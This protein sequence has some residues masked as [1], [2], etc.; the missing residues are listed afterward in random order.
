M[1]KEQLGRALAAT[2]RHLRD[3][4]RAWGGA[5]EDEIPARLEGDDR[6]LWS[7]RRAEWLARWNEIRIA[8]E[9]NQRLLKHSLRNLGMLVENFKRLIGDKPTYSAK[10]TR[11][12]SPFEGKVIEG[13][14]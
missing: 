4:A 2:R 7:R 1:R 5:G 8:C 13:R 11:V 14:F 6:V 9:R 3:A 12:D 10:G